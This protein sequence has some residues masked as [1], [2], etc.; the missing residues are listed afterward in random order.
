MDRAT[1][2]AAVHGVA[3]SQTQVREGTELSPLLYPGYKEQERGLA[4]LLPIGS[5]PYAEWG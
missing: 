2:H 1:W 5:G 3:K 4:G